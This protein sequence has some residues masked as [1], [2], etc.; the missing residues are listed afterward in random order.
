MSTAPS[1][2]PL[3]GRIPDAEFRS[4]IRRSKLYQWARENPG[5]FRKAGHAVIVDL[6]RLDEIMAALPPAELKK[7][8]KT[9]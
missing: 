6:R 7:P 3:F 8:T 9:A 4:G 2:G 1:A 5:L